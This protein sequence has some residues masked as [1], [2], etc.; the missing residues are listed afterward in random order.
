[1]A[2]KHKKLLST[3]R[4]LGDKQEPNLAQHESE[5]QRV[6]QPQ[7]QPQFDHFAE[8]SGRGQH[9]PKT[10]SNELMAPLLIT[11]FL[12]D[13][14]SELATGTAE[15]LHIAEAHTPEAH[16]PEAITPEATTPEITPQSGGA[17]SD[18]TATEVEPDE[19]KLDTATSVESVELLDEQPKLKNEP[20]ELEPR[21][22]AI[23]E[24]E[25]ELKLEPEQPTEVAVIPKTSSAQ[26]DTQEP[27]HSVRMQAEETK[28]EQPDRSVADHSVSDTSQAIASDSEVQAILKRPEAFALI[29]ITFFWT[30][31]RIYSGIWQQPAPSRKLSHRQSAHRSEGDANNNNHPG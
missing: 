16:T 4:A 30:I 25:P 8:E 24:P 22:P 11:S 19:S 1:M 5:E 9:E 3:I 17:V 14:L 12:E 15:T 20:E 26:E 31:W 27:E 28:P 10:A 18:E 2:R 13:Q 23:A 7:L 29:V 6:V 21:E